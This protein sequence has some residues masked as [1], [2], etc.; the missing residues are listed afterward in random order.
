MPATIIDSALFGD[1]FSNPAMRAIFSDE[2][3]IQYYLDIEGALARVQA[4]LGIIPQEAAEEINRHCRVEQIDMA[5]LKAQIDVIGHPVLPTVQQLVG[6]CAKGLGEWSHWGTTTQDIMDTA[7]ILQVRDAL[8]L[9][10]EDMTAISNSLAT[11][12]ERYR[13]TPMAGRTKTQ[14]AVPISF[15]LKMAILLATFMRHRARLE[16][17]RARVLVGQ[18]AGAAGTLASLGKDGLRVQRGLMAELGLGQPEI[19][20]HTMRD[21]FAEIGCF[22]GLLTGTL[23]KIATDINLMAQTEVQEVSESFTP[24]RGSSSTM[25][26]K[27]NPVSSSYI[28]G[29]TGVVRQQVAALLDAMVAEHERSNGPWE[30]EWIVLPEIFLLSSGALAH[31]RSLVAGLQV[32]PARMRKNLELTG[33]MI[34]AEAVM[35]GL[36]PY[37]GRQRAH[38]LVY[39]ICR[40]AVRSGRPLLDLLA[41]NPEISKHC[42]RSTLAKLTDPA[43]YL[44]VTGEM[45]DEVLAAY[46][47]AR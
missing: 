44:G 16:E 18:F 8:N 10:E 15:G 12:A 27:R 6:L 45:I 5:K 3:R 4:R 23:G 33:G 39:E 35:M 43:N 26:Q 46:R 14:Q 47:Q 24:G 37:L 36:G 40:A 32:D 1:T 13:D 2:R 25:P 34:V 20:W 41:E 7:A 42:D 21:R 38:D 9:V 30:I 22:L 19:G 29:C 17:L 28:L 11:L 31:T